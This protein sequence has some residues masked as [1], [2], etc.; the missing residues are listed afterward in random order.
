MKGLVLPKDRTSGMNNLIADINIWLSWSTWKLTN[1]GNRANGDFSLGIQAFL[2]LFT[3]FLLLTNQ[4]RGVRKWSCRK[5]RLCWKMSQ[6]LWFSW[7][8]HKQMSVLRLGR[9]LFRSLL[10]RLPDLKGRF[11][12]YLLQPSYLLQMCCFVEYLILF[13]NSTFAT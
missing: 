11:L 8:Q 9:S 5:Q 3:R 4:V 10:K 2:M 12:H 1:L 7:R 13:W 6:N